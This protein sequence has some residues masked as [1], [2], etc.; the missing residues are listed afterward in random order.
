MG[1]SGGSADSPS[2]KSC[3]ILGATSSI[4]FEVVRHLLGRGVRVLATGRDESRLRELQDM[5][6]ATMQV[7]A[8]KSDEVKNAVSEAVK[9]FGSLTAA[10]NC[11]GSIVLKPAHSTSEAEFIATLETNL[12]SAFFL[13]KHAAPVIAKAGGG[14]IVLM[15]SAVTQKGI[16][17]HEAIAAAKAGVN[18]LVLS[19]AA[20]YA[21]GGVRVNAVAPGL[22]DTRLAARI[23]SSE[24]AKQMSLAM[25]AL[26][27]FGSASDCASVVDLLLDSSRCSVITGQIICVDAGLGSLHPQKR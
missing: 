21:P 6:A 18:G 9:Q 10:L 8:R 12:H 26:G 4:S 7:D 3:L 2:P 25:H 5:G 27:R 23:M 17:N 24:P 11:A 19:A 13:V 1:T 16:A 15:S 22:T 20:T 14:S